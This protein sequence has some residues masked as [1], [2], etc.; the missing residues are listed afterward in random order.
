MNS[1]DFRKQEKNGT[2]YFPTAARLWRVEVAQIWKDA[3]GRF[4]TG[5]KH[6][7]ADDS[8]AAPIARRCLITR[9]RNASRREP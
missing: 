7:R 9:T 3:V 6:E 2:P 8:E 5:A 4:R 1:L